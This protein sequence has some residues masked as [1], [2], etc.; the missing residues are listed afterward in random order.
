M[1]GRLPIVHLRIEEYLH[2]VAPARDP[3]LAEME[4][5]A[6]RRGF[7]IVGP[8]VGALLELTA[9]ALG[10]G[11]VLELG[12]GFGYS[13]IWFARAVGPGGKVV[14]TESSPENAETGR[15]YLSRAGLDG[16]VEYRVGNALEIARDL[17]GPFDVI[18]NDIDK[19][20]YPLVPAVAERLLRPGGLLVSDNMLWRG[21]V[22]EEGGDP[23][24]RG[25]R[26]LTRLLHSSPDYL[27]TLIPLRDGV[28]LSLRLR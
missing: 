22:A 2:R 13:A 11:R 17:Q 5:V 15:G 8:L 27:T 18:F 10:A 3:V 26:E 1:E 7:P 23:K 24:T 9:R 6:A 20:D 25:V 28:T 16:R 4:E 14:A 21:S 19:Q 12:S